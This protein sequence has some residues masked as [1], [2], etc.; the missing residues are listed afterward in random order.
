M[1]LGQL[2]GGL[3]AKQWGLTAPYWVAFVATGVFL[4]IVWPWLK[5]IEHADEEAVGAPEP[6]A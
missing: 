4:A 3:I 2:L 1:A 6:T 5:L